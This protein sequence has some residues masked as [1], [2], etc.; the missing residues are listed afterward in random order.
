VV[1]GMTM[2]IV[3]GLIAAAYGVGR[4]HQFVRNARASMGLDKHDTRRQR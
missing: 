2:L 1:V 3:L 4:I